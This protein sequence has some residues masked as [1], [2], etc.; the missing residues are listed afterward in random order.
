VLVDGT[1]LPHTRHLWPDPRKGPWGVELRWRILDGRAECVGIELTSVDRGDG[2]PLTGTILRD[3]Q[4]PRLIAAD[5]AAM[6]GGATKGR[7][8]EYA[9]P[10]GMRRSAV[11]RYRLVATLYRDALSRGEMPIASV[12]EGLGVTKASASTIVARTRAA[13]FLPPA[14]P[15]VPQA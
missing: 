5:R 3:L 2:V 1:D 4:V 10:P 14:S 11:D 6:S 15:G 7:Q 13:G 9:G 8:A 12:A